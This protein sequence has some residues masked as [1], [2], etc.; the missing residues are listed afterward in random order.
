MTFDEYAKSPAQVT[1][2]HTKTQHK[3]L[4]IFSFTSLKGNKLNSNCDIDTMTVLT[5]VVLPPSTVISIYITS[6]QNTV[7]MALLVMDQ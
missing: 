1:H 5:Y 2:S 7:N 3:N 6:F 4:V